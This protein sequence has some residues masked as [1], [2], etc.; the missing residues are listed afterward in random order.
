MYRLRERRGEDFP[1][2]RKDLKHT[3][4]RGRCAIALVWRY[5]T[6]F[7][8]GGRIRVAGPVV[9]GDRE[10][11]TDEFGVWFSAVGEEILEVRLVAILWM[12]TKC[13]G[14]SGNWALW[15]GWIWCCCRYS[16][17]SQWGFSELCA[18]AE[19]LFESSFSGR[20]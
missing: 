3:F 2:F 12:V 8:A 1:A 13:F 6:K 17:R 10:A 5:D 18:K 15:C 16:G 11:D 14:P 19:W 20:T 9:E 4:G 7:S